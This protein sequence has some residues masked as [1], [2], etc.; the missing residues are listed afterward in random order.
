[1]QQMLDEIAPWMP[2]KPFTELLRRLNASYTNRL[3]QMWELVWLY[4]LGSVLPVEHEHPLPNGKPDVWFSVTDEERV[5]PVVAD[6]TTLSDATLHKANPFEQLSDAVHEQARKAGMQGG[7]FHIS[8][9]HREAG[10]SGA[11]KV[12]LQIPT[13]PEFERLVKRHIKPFARRVAAEPT[14]PHKLEVDEVGARFVVEYKGPS[15]YSGGSC[16]SYDN[17]LSLK[18]NALFNRLNDKTRQLRGAPEG[19]IRMLVVCDGDC[20]LL[21]HPSSLEGFN[22]QQVAEHF[23]RGSQTIDLVLL[24]TVVEESVSAF[25]RRSHRYMSCEL[26]AAPPGR[27]PAHMNAGVVA[28]VRRVLDD[29]VMKLPEPLMMP[30]NALRR[31]LDSEW[32]ASMEGGYEQ[33]GDRIK[34]SARAVLELLAGAMTYERFADVHGWTEDRSDLLRSCLASGQLFRKVRIEHLG[35]GQDDDWLV[36]EFGPPDPA[37]STFRMP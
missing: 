10:A 7:G 19:A 31:N 9:S 28:A 13:G 6:I 35:P 15:Q 21:S 18:N 27:R 26:V 20:A 30:N 37:I 29:A 8:V 34:V 25:G 14:D 17:V 36:F 32:S 22:A 23:L 5:V 1:M 24:V 12:Q 2:E 33:R 4:A 11:G 3:P 16:R